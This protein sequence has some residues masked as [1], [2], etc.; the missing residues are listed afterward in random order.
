MP[1]EIGVSSSTDGASVSHHEKN[2]STMWRERFSRIFSFFFRGESARLR[3]MRKSEP[4]KPSATFAR[5]GSEASALKKYRLAWALCRARHKA[6]YLEP[7]IIWGISE[8]Q[9]VG[10]DRPRLTLEIIQASTARRGTPGV[11]EMVASASVSEG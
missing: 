4:M 6:H 5:S 11:W 7:R 1:S 9:R 10:S 8:I 2:A 3:S